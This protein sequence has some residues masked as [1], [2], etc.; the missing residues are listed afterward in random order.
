MMKLTRFV[1]ESAGY[2]V[3]YT[4]Y[5]LGCVSL[6][7]VVSI[8]S[9]SEFGTNDDWEDAAHFTRQNS[10]IFC[11]KMYRNSSKIDYRANWMVLIY[12]RFKLFGDDLASPLMILDK[13]DQSCSFS[14]LSSFSR[15]DFS[16]HHIRETVLSW[17]IISIFHE[18]II[19]HE[20][21]RT[22]RIFKNEF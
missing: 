16:L 11:S 21:S 22:P 2:D 18:T 3:R 13:S 10:I 12:F 14:K 19:I 7:V 5:K 1:P 20:H 6:M 15:S 17:S 9:H 4:I 8:L